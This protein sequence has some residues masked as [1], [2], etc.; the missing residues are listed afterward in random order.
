MFVINTNYVIM[1]S[2]KKNLR[3]TYYIE[4]EII[5][6]IKRY[7]YWEM[8]GTS[9]IVNKILKDFFKNKKYPDIPPRKTGGVK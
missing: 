5:A 2:I 3:Q 1:N 8:T 7:T 4:P 9:E 6:Q